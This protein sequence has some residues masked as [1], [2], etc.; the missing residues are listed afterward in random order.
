[1]RA[2]SDLIDQLAGALD[3]TGAIIARVRPEQAWL[4]TP[5]QS[6]DVR[7]LVNHVVRDVLQFTARARGEAWEQADADLI[8]DDWEGAFREAANGLLAAWRAEG[9]L[10]TTVKLPFGEVPGTWFVGQQIAD[11]VVHGWDIAKATAQ[12]ADFDPDLEQSSL[13]WGRENLKPEFRGDEASGRVFGPEVAVSE[14]A[15]VLD[16]LIGFFGRDPDW[17]G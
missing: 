8:R 4:P 14:D 17:K 7:E 1:V 16:R 15:P 5:C 13:D 2:D 10:D 12:S 6:W 3:R 11:F 9:A